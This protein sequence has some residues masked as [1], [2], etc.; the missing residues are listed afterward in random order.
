MTENQRYSPLHSRSPSFQLFIAL[1]YILAGACLFLLFMMAAI[2]IF[3]PGSDILNNPSFKPQLKDIVFLQYSLITQHLFLFVLP[4]I[5]LLYRFRSHEQP[6]YPELLLPSSGDII[7]TVI[8][9]FCFLPLTGVAAEV[10]S[11]LKFP[12]FLSGMEEWVI[13]NE[14]RAERLAEIIL[15]GKT[16]GLI[17]VNSFMMTV[18]PAIG[19]ELIF[20]GIL[21]KIFVRMFRSGYAGVIITSILFSALHFQFMGFLPRFLIGLVCGLLFLWSGKLWLPVIV[22]FINN[23][24]SL[25]GYYLSEPGLADDKGNIGLISK[26]AMVLLLLIPFTGIMN[27]FRKRFIY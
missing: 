10:N 19:E 15:S 21:Q 3:E 25:T 23:S 2:F 13:K 11:A 24:I 5:F 6:G 22:H 27:S 14:S 1:V 8:L 20:R 26:A 7:S 9:T 17:I 12:V 4:G 18:M 16:A